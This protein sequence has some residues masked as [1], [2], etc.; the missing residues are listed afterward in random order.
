MTV[1]IEKHVRFNVANWH[2]AKAAYYWWRGDWD[3]YAYHARMGDRLLGVRQ[4]AH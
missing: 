3:T 4:H 2:Y 1:K